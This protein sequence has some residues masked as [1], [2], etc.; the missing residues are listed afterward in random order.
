[1]AL[2]KL[3]YTGQGTV[4]IASVPTITGA[5]MPA[6]SVLQVVYANT[7]TEVSTTSTTFADTGLTA[8]I[9][10]IS[11][12][13]KILITFTVFQ[14]MTNSA[15][16][17]DL[18]IVRGSTDLQTYGFN[19]YAGSSTIMS[20]NSYQYVDSPSTTSPTTYKI[21]YNCRGEG[22]VICQYDDGNGDGL[23]TMTLQEIAG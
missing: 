22:T 12:S 18:K 13:S 4:P 19:N 11:T 21:Q 8:T 1:M 3:N 6:G 23:S 15:G 20:S 2:T 9:T 7:T 5:K 14:F 10:P 17:G 16:Y